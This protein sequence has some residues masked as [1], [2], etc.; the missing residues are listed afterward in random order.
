MLQVSTSGADHDRCSG[1]SAGQVVACEYDV[2][3]RILCTFKQ[4]SARCTNCY[5]C[6]HMC[7]NGTTEWLLRRRNRYMLYTCGMLYT[8]TRNHLISSQ[9]NTMPSMDLCQ[10]A[11]ASRVL[12]EVPQ[13]PTACHLTWASVLM[14]AHKCAML[15]PLHWSPHRQ[16]PACS[17]SAL[18]HAP[19]PLPP[20]HTHK[21]EGA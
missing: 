6:A 12:H 4:C 1:R 9:A 11:R 13:T 19:P 7:D 17:P 8:I 5:L 21:P 3:V 16:A 10:Q 18:P 15:P 14:P 20:P 2:H